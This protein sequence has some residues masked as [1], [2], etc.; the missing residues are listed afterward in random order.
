MH[1]GLRIHNCHCSEVA[2]I[3]TCSRFEP[4]PGNSYMPWAQ[5]KK[6]K[7]KGTVGSQVFPKQVL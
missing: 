7:T 4:C 3:L 1:S 6:I 2:W 5:P